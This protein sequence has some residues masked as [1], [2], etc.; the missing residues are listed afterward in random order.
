[1]QLAGREDVIITGWLL[2]HHP[3]RFNIVPS[4][5]PIPLGIEIPK[6]EHVELTMLDPSE[7]HRDLPGDKF[8]STKWR[9]MIEENPGTRVSA[10]IFAI[11]DG[12]PMAVQLSYGIRATRVE[13]CR[14]RLR[15]RGISAKHLRRRRLKEPKLR[16][17]RPGRLEQAGD[18]ERITIPCIDRHRLM[19]SKGKSVP[20]Q[21]SLSER[22]GDGRLRL[23]RSETLDLDRVDVL[24]Y[25]QELVV[26]PEI[27]SLVV[28]V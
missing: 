18:A 23:L 12:H 3:H 5:A 26:S 2:Q 1:M 27:Q 22:A 4:K 21:P 13:W 8:L 17:H 20:S 15:N 11:I 6:I 7:R 10:E 9:F 25:P 19:P 14:F 28:D 24:E 16:I